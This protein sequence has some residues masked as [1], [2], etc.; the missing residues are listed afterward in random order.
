M[1]SSLFSFQN[2]IVGV[3]NSVDEILK[4]QAHS[5]MLV[6]K[7]WYRALG[8]KANVKY[9][10]MFLCTVI[11]AAAGFQVYFVRRLFSVSNVTPS[12]KPRA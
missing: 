7:D 6:M 12:K 9:W 10:S 2:S 8:N 1:K 3:E 4:Y 5:R 11:I